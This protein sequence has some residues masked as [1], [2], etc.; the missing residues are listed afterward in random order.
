MTTSYKISKSNSSRTA[1]YSVHRCTCHIGR[2]AVF[3]RRNKNL[4]DQDGYK[5]CHVVTAVCLFQRHNTIQYI[6]Y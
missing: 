2:L 4:T 6:Q 5:I 3:I 1:R